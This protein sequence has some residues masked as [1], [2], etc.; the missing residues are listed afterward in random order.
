MNG[1]TNEWCALI[2]PVEDDVQ[3]NTCTLQDKKV[4]EAFRF[5]ITPRKMVPVR[6]VVSVVVTIESH[7]F[8]TD[9]TT[10]SVWLRTCRNVGDRPLV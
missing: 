6:L 3:L 10:S 4:K 2:F 7:L 5:I 9:Q 1:M 8:H